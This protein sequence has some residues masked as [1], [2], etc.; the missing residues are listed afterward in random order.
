MWWKKKAGPANRTLLSAVIALEGPQVAIHWWK[1]GEPLWIANTARTGFITDA[2]LF[3]G[4]DY[5][6]VRKQP[7]RPKNE[8]RY[9]TLRAAGNKT[10]GAVC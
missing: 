4:V 10:R 5:L 6:A 3:V 1:S 9:E 2:K 7:R 8:I